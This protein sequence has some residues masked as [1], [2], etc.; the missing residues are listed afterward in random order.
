MLKVVLK[1]DTQLHYKSLGP[2]KCT[3]LTQTI[4][5]VLPIKRDISSKTPKEN[6]L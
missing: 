5:P 6:I 2:K 3:I 4:H 1:Q